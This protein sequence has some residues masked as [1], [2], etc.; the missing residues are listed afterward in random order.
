MKV[1]K[2]NILILIFAK[3]NNLISTTMKINILIP[4]EVK[5]NVLTLD[6]LKIKNACNFL[7]GMKLN[8]LKPV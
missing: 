3:I 4:I 5:I 1:F 2:I 7:D 6:S 8:I